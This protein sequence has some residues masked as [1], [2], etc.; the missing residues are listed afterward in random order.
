MLPRPVPA[1]AAELREALHT[2]DI[3][4]LRALFHPQVHW[5]STGPG[6]PARYGRAA[7]LTWYQVR[8]DLG[9]RTQT[10]ET[11]SLPAAII[12]ALHITDPTTPDTTPTLYYRVFH[13]RGGQIT[14]I[15]D[16]TDRAHALE[17]ATRTL[18]TAIPR[19]TNP[20]ATT[21][22]LPDPDPTR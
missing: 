17:A 8:Y 1:I 11:L 6:D 3:R 22:Q 18:P 19:S 16:H 14:H 20:Q 7:A 9:V 21:A 13:L 4:Q 15:R 5:A 2:A 10:Q 12:L